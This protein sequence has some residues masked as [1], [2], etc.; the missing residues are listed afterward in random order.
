MDTCPGYGWDKATRRENCVVLLKFS[1]FRN[2]RRS[3]EAFY[4][5][6]RE[7]GKDSNSIRM[8][9]EGSDGVGCLVVAGSYCSEEQNFDL[10]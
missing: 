10:I 6:S 2:R 3:V 5:L 4:S 7:S 8:R 9:R 1:A